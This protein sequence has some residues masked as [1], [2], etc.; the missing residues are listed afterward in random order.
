[1]FVPPELSSLPGIRK[2]I[3]E[4][5]KIYP[6]HGNGSAPLIF[7]V[8]RTRLTGVTIFDIRTDFKSTII[9]DGS[10]DVSTI[11]CAWSN[12]DLVLF[13]KENTC[14]CWIRYTMNN[15]LE[16]KDSTEVLLSQGALHPLSTSKGD[17][18]Q[19]VLIFYLDFLMLPSENQVMV[20]LKTGLFYTN[21]TNNV[22]LYHSMIFESSKADGSETGKKGSTDTPTKKSH[23]WTVYVGV[24]ATVLI[25]SISV[26]GIV[27]YYYVRQRRQHRCRSELD[28][29]ER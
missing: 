5:K 11:T 8:N 19:S 2:G 3:W 20:D 7:S 15:N 13:Y 23:S 26:I 16:L 28:I 25:M 4:D 9:L 18:D 21:I 24:A 29:A 17:I 22:V 1:M 12:N 6:C 10:P 27:S 14:D